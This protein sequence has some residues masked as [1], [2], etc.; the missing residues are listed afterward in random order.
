MATGR[1]LLALLIQNAVGANGF[2]AAMTTYI[3][4]VVFLVAVCL[5]FAYRR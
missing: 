1:A 4:I 2:E 5:F 3:G